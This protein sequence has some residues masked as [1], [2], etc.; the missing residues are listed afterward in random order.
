VTRGVVGQMLPTN[1]YPPAG[2]DKA[3][4]SL[5]GITSK[6]TYVKVLLDK[7]AV[8]IEQDALSVHVVA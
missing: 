8:I 7:V 1:P 3:K 4:K 5:L 6:A 2:S